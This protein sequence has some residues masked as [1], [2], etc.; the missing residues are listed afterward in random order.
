MELASLASLREKK[1]ME[2]EAQQLR[3]EKEL[4]CTTVQGLDLKLAMKLV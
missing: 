1:G 4:L 2:M 3:E